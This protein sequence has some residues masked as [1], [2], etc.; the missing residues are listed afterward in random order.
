MPA[1]EPSAMVRNLLL[2][3]AST[4]PGFGLPDCLIRAELALKLFRGDISPGPLA[5]P[6]QGA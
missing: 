5:E 1:V 6:Q 4:T 2:L 3:G